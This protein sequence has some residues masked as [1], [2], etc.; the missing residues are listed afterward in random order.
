[1]QFF[2]GD[3]IRGFGYI[4]NGGV[5]TVFR[6][7]STFP[8]TEGFVPEG[9]PFGPEGDSQR[10]DVESFLHA[11]DSNMA[12]IV[13]QQVTLDRTNAATAGPRIDLLIS[14]ASTEGGSE[15]HAPECELVVTTRLF[16]RER[17]YLYL[18]G[19]GVFRPSEH[20]QPD[21]TDAQ[22]RA[23]AWFRELTYTCVP[24]GSG[25]RVALDA[26]LDGCYNVTEVK[27]GSDPRDPASK[28]AAC[29]S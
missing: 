3:Q 12:P 29:P 8:F 24:L 25:Q 6:F 4:H 15:A 21:L 26:D 1:M 13:G 19:P 17:G 9:F 14:R 16:G 5:D 23:L 2:Q 28:A 27:K 18:D 7:L 10:R 22:L 11:F 20:G